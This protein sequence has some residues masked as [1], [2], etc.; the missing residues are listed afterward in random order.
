MEICGVLWVEL[1]ILCFFDFWEV[2]GI[3]YQALGVWIADDMATLSAVVIF[4]RFF[5]L[6]I[7]ALFSKLLIM[8]ELTKKQLL[9][10]WFFTFWPP[11]IM[12]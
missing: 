6:L 3:C 2:I 12:D 11:D 7:A 1:V 10:F 9:K 4:P 8:P 5:W